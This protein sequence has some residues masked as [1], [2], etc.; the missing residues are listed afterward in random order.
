MTEEAQQLDNGVIAELQNK[1]HSSLAQ[2]LNGLTCDHSDIVE[3]LAQYLVLSEQD[4]DQ[5]FDDWYDGLCEDQQLVLKGFEI[6]RAH[7]ENTN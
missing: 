2:Q 5:K 7:Y 1:D 3:L 4:D 6:I